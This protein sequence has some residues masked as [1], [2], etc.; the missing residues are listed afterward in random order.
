[1][2]R[3]A[4]RARASGT[5][6]RR[7]HRGQRRRRRRQLRAAGP[8]GHRGRAVGGDDRPASA[9][10]RRRGAGRRRGAA[11]RRRELRRRD[12]P[13]SPSSTGATAGRRSRSCGAS[14][15]PRRRLLVGPDLRRRHV[16]RPEYFPQSRDDDGFPSLAEQA[17]ALGD[18]VDVVPVP[19][20]CRDG[21]CSAFWRRP[22]ANLDPCVRRRHIDARPSAVD[23]RSAAARGHDR[24][25]RAPRASRP[26]PADA[27]S[28]RRPRTRRRRPAAMIGSTRDRRARPSAPS[29]SQATFGTLAAPR[30]SGAPMPVAGQLGAD[31]EAAALDLG[32]DGGAESRPTF[33][34]GAARRRGRAQ[35]RLRRRAASRAARASCSPR[36]RPGGA[37]RSRRARRITREDA[38][39]L[40]PSCVAP[41]RRQARRRARRRSSSC[42]SERPARAPGLER[43]QSLPRGRTRR[44]VRGRRPGVPD[45]RLRRAHRRAGR[46][47]RLDGPRRRAQLAQGPRLR[48]GATRTARR[49]SAAIADRHAAASDVRWWCPCDRSHADPPV[50]AATSSSCTID[51][52][53]Y[54]GNGVA[55]RD[56]YVVFVAGAIPGDRVRAVVGKR[57]RRYAEARA[58][59]I[60]RARARPH[61]RRS[62]TIPA[63]RG[64]CCPTSASSRSRPS[65][66]SDALR[67]IGR[68]EGF[69]LEP[70]VP[71][72]EQWRYRNKLEYSFGTGADGELVCGFHAPGRWDE[73]VA[74]RPTACSPPSAATRCASRSLAWCRDAGPDA[75]RTAARPARLPAQPRRA[76]GPAHR[77]DRR[78]GWSPRPASSTSTR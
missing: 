23:A 65:R 34:P 47:R 26:R 4:H 73:I 10:R 72:V 63:R 3:V 32:L 29:P 8:R 18:R 43:P 68:L 27:S 12:A 7:A 77:P 1:M 58:I 49:C 76:R 64:R 41:G 11:V 39:E 52:L 54:G 51:S 15:A 46:R 56:G 13:C 71:A 24:G 44:A 69:E 59:E 19:R 21:F 2:G 61:R 40:A 37:R 35:R 57:K 31:A 20:D 70:I 75:R 67:R 22:D 16:A 5:P 17:A 62:P 36:R 30:G 6:W 66:S 55:R 53:A 78:C 50:S 9:R 42:S 60:A 38:T 74:D 25:R 33:A 48:D 28:R 45:P 14:R